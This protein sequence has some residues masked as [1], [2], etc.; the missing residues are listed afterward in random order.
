[1]KGR[2]HIL[3]QGALLSAFALPACSDPS[4]PST[5]PVDL[6]IAGEEICPAHENWL[7]GDTP[8]YS[9]DPETFFKPAAHPASECPFYS[10]AWQNFLY[11]TQPD[12]QGIPRLASYSTIDDIFTPI[13]ALP[14]GAL[15]PTGSP[16]GNANRS[17]LGLIEQAGRREVAIDQNGRTLYYGIHVNQAFVD[18]VK[19]QGLTTAYAIQ[20]APNDLVLPPGMVEFKSAWQQVDDGQDVGTYVSTKAWVPNITVDKSGGSDPATWKLV[21]DHNHPHEITVRL[22]ALHVVVTFPGHPE[23]FWGHLE[24]TDVDMGDANQRDWKAENGYRS[25]APVTV[26]R[27]ADKILLNPDDKDNTD[28]PDPVSDTGVNAGNKQYIL[29][30]AGTPTQLS[31]QAIENV[32]QFFKEESQKF[33]NTDGSPVQTSIYRLFPASK[34]NTT[35][36]DDAISSLNHNVEALFRKYAANLLPNDF[37]GNYRLLGGQWMDKPAFFR[38]N[39]LIQNDANDPTDFLLD[40]RVHPELDATQAADRDAVI[41]H[42]VGDPA[43]SAAVDDIAANG[44]DSPFSILAGEDRMSGAPL[45]SFTQ[46]RAQFP[47]CFSCHNTKTIASHGVPY[48]GPT[49]GSILLSPKLIN[50]SHVFSEFVRDE[51]DKAPFNTKTVRDTDVNTIFGRD[52]HDPAFGNIDLGAQVALCPPPS[53]MPPTGGAGQ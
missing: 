27:D 13:E 40:G 24:H 48:K 17:W 21:E 53:G 14:A 8:E 18:F 46:P 45:E 1:M 28:I 43:V 39:S 32:A 50:V 4:A 26:R 11:A 6:G 12:A 34:S 36:P 31:S 19:D 52:L 35:H 47:N 22:L 5:T 38:L 2:V 20:N 10:L 7:S 37:R 16:R 29:Y 51:C 49:D 25:I 33:L 23:F 41:G 42:L 3:V 9:T 30:K 15:N 44:S